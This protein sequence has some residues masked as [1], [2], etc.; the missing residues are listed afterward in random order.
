MAE[1]LVTL[2]LLFDFSKA[3]DSVCHVKLLEKFRKLHFDIST[4][5]WVASY[6]TGRKQA[7]LDD[8]GVPSPFTPLQGCSLRLCAWSSAIHTVHY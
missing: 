8:N 1:Q 2:L 5:K 7:V 6:L 3:F 4:L